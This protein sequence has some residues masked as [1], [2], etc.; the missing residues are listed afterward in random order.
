MKLAMAVVLGLFFTFNLILLLNGVGLIIT[1]LSNMDTFLDMVRPLYVLSS[2]FCIRKYSVRDGIVATISRKEMLITI[3]ANCILVYL[4]SS[5][6]RS[7]ELEEISLKLFYLVIYGQHVFSFVIISCHN[8]RLSKVF[9][10]L[11]KILQEIYNFE[12]SQLSSKA[13]KRKLMI[14]C[15]ILIYL[16]IEV[17][18]PKIVLDPYWNWY[19]C[20]FLGLSIIVDFEMVFIIFVIRF[21]ALKFKTW[22]KVMIKYSSDQKNYNCQTNFMNIDSPIQEIRNTSSRRK[23]ETENLTERRQDSAIEVYEEFDVDN[24]DEAKKLFEVYDQ[25]VNSTNLMKSAFQFT[26]R[27]LLV[28][29]SSVFVFPIILFPQLNTK[30]RSGVLISHSA[31]IVAWI[32]KALFIQAFVGYEMECLYTG[33]RASRTAA[34]VL[35]GRRH[36]LATTRSAKNALRLSSSRPCR[37]KAVGAL[38]VDAALP[39]RLAALVGSYT[40]VLLQFALP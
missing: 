33:V 28:T 10:E 11:I 12:R 24:R 39:L 1:P 13:V 26:V 22:S 9:V 16:Y 14:A 23:Y 37:F 35:V 34:C 5:T 21:L 27:D 7:T 4:F 2:I 32:A 31:G 38:P 25:L 8:M 3:S 29:F 17:T 20:L 15:G 18:I 19:R 40:V 36:D 30:T 6:F